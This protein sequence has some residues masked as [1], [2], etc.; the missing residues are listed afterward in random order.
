MGMLID[1]S[2]M[3]E[4]ETIVNGAYIRPNSLLQRAQEAQVVDAMRSSPNRYWLIA[5]HSCPWSHR[6]TITH[7]IK[8]L[9]DLI[10]VHYAH[11]KRVQGYPLDGGESWQVPGTAKKYHHLHELYSLHDAQYSGQETVPVIWDSETHTIVSNES[12]DIIGAFDAVSP[13]NNLNFTLRPPQLRQEV[14]TINNWIYAGLNNAVYRAGFAQHQI[15]YRDAVTQVF[16]TLDRLEHRLTTRRYL[17][18]S[19]VTETDWRLFVSL[20]RFDAVYVTHF[21]CT[22]RRVIDYPALWA[23]T[24]DLWGWRGVSD[25]VDFDAILEGY[26]L[27]DGDHNPHGIVAEAP[28]TDWSASHDRGELG[29]SQVWCNTVG[30]VTIDPS[31]LQRIVD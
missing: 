9:E 30:A 3:T 13:D 15:E 8:G 7:R 25:T 16:E 22:R 19:V 23:Y 20:V 29:P 1:G 4:D 10:P 26:Y 12:S 31:T 14:D 21:R 5:S 24:R 28:E 27:N 11:G 2:W 17:F 18:G 6:A